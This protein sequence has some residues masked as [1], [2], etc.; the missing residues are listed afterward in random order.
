MVNPLKYFFWTCSGATISLISSKECETEHSKYV[1]IG[2]AIFLTGIL[3]GVAASYAF[4]TV[5]DSVGWSLTFGF[6]WGV[7][8][9]N[10]DRYLVLSIRKKAPEEAATG[11]ETLR[12][13]GSLIVMTAPRVALAAL[14]AVV[15][16]K[17]LELMIFDSEISLEMKSLR[18]DRQKEF[19]RNLEADLKDG[20]GTSLAARIDKLEKENKQLQREIDEREQQQREFEQR[21]IDEAFGRAGL[22]A[23]EGE[24]FKLKREQAHNQKTAT[25]D[26]AK[27]RRERI[28]SN[29]TDLKNLKAKKTE[30]EREA[31]ERSKDVQGLA[32]RLQAFSRLTQRD[33][34]VW[35]ANLLIVL[36][37]LIL[38]TAPILTKIYASYGPYDKLVDVAELKVYLEKDQELEDM[39]S[40]IRDHREY[41]GRRKDVLADIQKWVARDTLDETSNARQGSE[42]YVNL[43]RAK[44]TLIEE[45]TSGLTHQSSNG[46][47]T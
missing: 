45:A 38:E 17:P 46:D 7:M 21:A 14:L 39:R 29:E 18:V 28:A 47:K 37:I 2:A 8:I 30:L 36:I 12:N 32:S 40:G 31:E 43:Q 11:R 20:E 23:G 24:V 9:F 27:S 10:L 4:F 22:P 13:W 33:P 25:E 6:F 16:A 34:V 1:G 42:A 3:A 5:F 15:I 35:Y 41:Y 44:K 19:M 26:F